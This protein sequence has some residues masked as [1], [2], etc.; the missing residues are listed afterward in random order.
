MQTLKYFF[1]V[2]K[3]NAISP[4]IFLGIFIGLT[5]VFSEFGGGPMDDFNVQSFNISV[6][7]RDNHPVSQGLQDVLGELHT[8]VHVEDDTAAMQE[9]LFF[10]DALY[11]LIIDEGFGA[12]FYA[13]PTD[14]TV[15]LAN[16]Q[17]PNAAI[18]EQFVGGQIDSY[19]IALRAFLT[20]DFELDR[21][22]T[23]A[24][25][26]HEADIRILNP[27][28]I[29]TGSPFYFQF[30]PFAFLN[31]VILSLGTV[32][33]VY[34]REVL[35]RRMDISP[36]PST[37]I[38]LRIMLGC[39]VCALALWAAFMVGGHMLGTEPLYSEVGLMRVANTLALLAFCVSLAFLIG[40]F[41]T[42]TV[43]L[44][45]IV[46][47]VGLGLCFAS[48]VFVP[49]QF[50]GEG[51]LNIARFTPTYWHVRFND[52]LNMLGTPDTSVFL[53]SI[54]IQL[55]FAVAIFA[56]ALA[57]GREKRAKA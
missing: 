31:V 23:L 14:P 20:A 53:Q 32:L 48:G 22:I 55:G 54:G 13:N 15:T 7:N 33:I 18:L 56:V 30:L 10:Q 25:T 35:V 37:S 57:L 9:A 42:K 41:V 36:T 1:T 29:V 49:Q 40:Q 19:L 27:D 24:A 46:Q 17:T 39:V 51:V 12:A 11:I 38:K 28:L 16:M 47:V 50:L 26:Q 2:L 8:L 3:K 21:A 5:V 4:L 52:S 34:K 43:T 6:V 45:G 44:T